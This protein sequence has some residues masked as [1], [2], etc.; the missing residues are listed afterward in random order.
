MVLSV[1]LFDK[2]HMDHS[3]QMIMPRIYIVHFIQEINNK[4]TISIK[5]Q[6]ST[7]VRLMILLI[8]CV[9]SHVPTQ[10]LKWPESLDAQWAIDLSLGIIGVNSAV[11]TIIGIFQDLASQRLLNEGLL[12]YGKFINILD[13]ILFTDHVPVSG[14]SG[15]FVLE[16]LKT[17]VEWCI[18][19]IAL[20]WQINAVFFQMTEQVLSGFKTDATLPA[21][22]YL[23][24]IVIV[25]LW[26]DVT[27]DMVFSSGNW[28][29][30]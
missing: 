19:Q 10:I 8:T 22:C 28:W 9:W 16:T 3:S 2:E 23:V 12:G 29:W 26:I 5:Y 13:L 4:I 14:V 15:Y 27:I 6:A 24:N 18:T 25:P 1:E 20:E 17:I 11:I 30:C 21:F 7:D